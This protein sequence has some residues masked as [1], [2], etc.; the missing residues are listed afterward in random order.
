MFTKPSIST[1]RVKYRL[2]LGK[3]G[4]ASAFFVNITASCQLPLMFCELN[5][6]F[7]NISVLFEKYIFSVIWFF[8]FS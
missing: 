8:L 5:P 6:F 3:H 4:I 2:I 1:N 7:Y